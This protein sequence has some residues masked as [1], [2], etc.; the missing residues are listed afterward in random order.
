MAV[1][2]AYNGRCAL[3]GLPEPLL[4][5]TAHIVADKDE[6]YG[7]PVVSNGIPLSKTHHAAF[8]AHLIGI[9]PDYRLHVSDRLLAQNDGHRSPE[10]APQFT[11]QV[12]PKTS[13]KVGSLEARMR[14]R[15][16]SSPAVSM[17]KL[18]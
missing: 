14:P 3:S 9:D 18:P 4:L 8:D 6:R 11:C 7:Q 13:P 17:T 16:V 1:I 12:A 10:A 2:T 5:D 15:G